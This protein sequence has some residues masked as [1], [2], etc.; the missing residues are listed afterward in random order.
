[1]VSGIAVD[2]SSYSELL[3]CIIE[4]IIPDVL[5]KCSAFVFGFEES[6]KKC[7]L[8]LFDLASEVTAIL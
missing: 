1:L 6:N 7:I 4:V 5:K 2:K 8:V 3:H